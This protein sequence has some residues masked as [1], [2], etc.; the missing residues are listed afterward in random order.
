MR[1]K[2]KDSAD[3]CWDRDGEKVTYVKIQNYTWKCVA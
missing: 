2:Q 1:M 3:V